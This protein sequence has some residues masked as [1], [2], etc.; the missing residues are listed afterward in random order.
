M[1]SPLRWL[2]LAAVLC[3]PAIL[4]AQNKGQLAPVLEIEKAWNGAP[5][6]FDDLVGHVVILDFAQTW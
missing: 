2:S 6:S 5:E 3:T 4:S 1:R